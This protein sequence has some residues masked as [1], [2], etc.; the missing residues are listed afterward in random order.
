MMLPT[1]HSAGHA[2]P[3]LFDGHNF[4]AD[5]AGA[6]AKRAT[7][8]RIVSDSGLRVVEAVAAVELQ[9]PDGPVRARVDEV[10]VTLTAERARDDWRE[11]VEGRWSVVDNFES[12][13]RRFLIA[14]RGGGVDAALTAREQSA[15]AYR[16]RGCSL[17]LIAAEL[18]RTVSMVARDIDRGM[19]KLGLRGQ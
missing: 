10:D 13:G 7:D 8:P 9:E 15:L 5:D 6:G 2:G 16:A 3:W 18:G 1:K 19:S 17:K 14:R 4:D 11:L 12:G